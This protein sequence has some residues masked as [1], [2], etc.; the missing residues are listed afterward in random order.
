MSARTHT[1][2]LGRML[3]VAGAGTVMFTAS[4]A[5]AP[6]ASADD[7]DRASAETI[8]MVE[9]KPWPFYV[10]GQVDI[11]IRAAYRA[12]GQQGFDSGVETSEFTDELREEVLEYQEAHEQYLPV[13]G[14]LDEETWLLLREQTYADEYVPGDGPNNGRTDG[15][16]SIQELLMW[17][18]DADIANDGWYGEETFYA[19][20]DAQEAYGLDADGLVGRL[21]WRS[22]ITDQD[23]DQDSARELPQAQVPER[24]PD[25]FMADAEEATAQYSCADRPA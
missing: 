3:A 11:D 9:A 6:T 19:V 12:L 22:L 23:W 8:A 13:T 21:T 4:V 20:C 15:V 14:N 7:M 24:V 25:G 1:G 16:L 2:F 10:H 5:T 17:K 18:H